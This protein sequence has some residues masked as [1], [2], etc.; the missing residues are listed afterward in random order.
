MKALILS[1]GS[2]KRFWPLSR[3]HNPKQYLRLFNNRSMIELTFIRLLKHFQIKDIFIVTTESQVDL[4]K[5]HIPDISPENIIIE[6][7]G[8]NTAPCIG[9]AC[10]Y[11]FYQSIID[12]V[13][14]VFPADHYIVDDDDYNNSI[15]SAYSAAAQNKL[16]TFGINPTYPATGYGYIERG[17]LF[18]DNTFH[19]K[20]FK[21]KP[22]IDIALKF[23]ESGNFLWNSGMFAWK[24]SFILYSYKKYLP[25]ISLLL[26]SIALNNFSL[27]Y[28]KT[29]YHQ[30]PKIPIDIGILEVS[31]STVVVPSFFTW[32]DV[33]SWKAYLDILPLFPSNDTSKTTP[34]VINSHNNLLISK[35][36]MVVSGISN[37]A[38]IESEDSI[39]IINLNESESVKSLVDMLEN[40]KLFEYL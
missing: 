14:F 17:D 11:I 2:G 1:G 18:I 31:D 32:S 40:K 33:G 39:L 6:P 38:V 34:I 23:L 7:E 10:K 27:S 37:V 4:V 22:D 29:I 24:L 25:E 20:H 26:D 16:V 36:L 8:R 15:L 5:E 30:M 28:S 35:K 19:V 13:L 12:D 21:E 3:T 9:L